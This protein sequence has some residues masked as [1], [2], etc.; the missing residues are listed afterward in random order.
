MYAP[1]VF[2]AEELRTS[3]VRMGDNHIFKYI[4][5]N[6]LEEML[7]AFHTAAKLNVMLITE[8]GR[9]ILSFGDQYAF[10]RDYLQY[11]MPARTCAQEHARAGQMARDF[12]ESYVFSCHSGLHHIVYPV[13]VKGKQF[14][15]VLAGPFLMEEPDET[16]AEDMEVSGRITR[17]RIAILMKDAGELPVYSPEAVTQISV[18]FRYLMRSVLVESRAIIA[19]NKEKLL[20]QSRINESIQ[21][22][23]N[24]GVREGR[25]YPIELENELISSIKVNNV[26]KARKNLN[27]LLGHILLYEGHDT[28]KIKLRI[29][30]LCALLSRAAIS[31]G[32][33]SNTV[34]ETTQQL[35]LAISRSRSVYD[36]CYRFQD[37]IEIFTDSIFQSPE[38]NS[39]VIKNAVD[40]IAHHFPEEITLASVAEEY[41]VNASY[42]SMLFR[43]VTGMTFKEYLNRVRVEE[44]ERL[45]TNTDYPIIDIAVACGYRDQSYFTK[46]FKKYT[47]LTPRQYR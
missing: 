25:S 44:A 34:L 10:C 6:D 16:L 35:I 32:A 20:Q 42:L 21:L 24:S 18:L 15:S 14:G 22:Y 37:N 36:I 47:G 1:E 46:V 29:V 8:D 17:D 39:R 41:H 31:R 11:G 23:K 9:A 30:E 26:E 43:Q 13:M 38:K 3:G 2:P 28:E 27:T 4:S 5:R 12:G 45:L 19:T 33:D 40:Y 7:R